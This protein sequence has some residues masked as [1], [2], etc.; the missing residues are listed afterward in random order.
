MAIQ[1]SQRTDHNAKNSIGL[2]FGTE[3]ARE[4]L[5]EYKPGKHLG[6]PSSPIPHGVLNQYLPSRFQQIGR[7]MSRLNTNTEYWLFS[8]IPT[9]N[10]IPQK[11]RR[12][13]FRT[14][15]PSSTCQQLRDSIFFDLHQGSIN[16][17]AKSSIAH[18]SNRTPDRT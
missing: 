8:G 3:S 16:I 10:A 12:Q 6:L 13:D 17:H 7:I 15:P 9:I 4:A 2:D 1:S 5:V 18:H 14:P 11:V